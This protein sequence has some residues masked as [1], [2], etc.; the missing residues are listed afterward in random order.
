MVIVTILSLFLTSCITSP[1]GG[2]TTDLT[3]DCSTLEGAA[4]DNC[5]SEKMQCSKII[6][7]NVKGSCV[8]ELAKATSDLDVCN[9]IQKDSIKA[10]CQEQ[11]SEVLND[12][13]ICEQI[14]DQYWS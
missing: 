13:T 4:M 1:T 3:T 14:E 6:S 10:Y 7:E 12:V 5:Y 9:L 2:I 8:A 11:V